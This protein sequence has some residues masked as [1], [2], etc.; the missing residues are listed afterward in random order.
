M[1]QFH[2]RETFS[3]NDK[4]LFVM[5]GFIIEGEV[6]AGM[7]VTMPFNATVK[8]TAE[9]DHLQYLN[10]PDGDVVCLCIRCTDPAEITLWEALK[11]K[12][13]NVDI[14]KPA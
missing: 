13:K 11:I 2:V 9:I 1:P 4:S 7:L 14:I 12:N 5:A 3:I 8:M 6:T 10:R